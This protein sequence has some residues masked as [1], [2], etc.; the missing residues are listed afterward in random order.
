MKT[1]Y[2]SDLDGTLLNNHAEISEY[3]ENTLN[4]LIQKGLLFSV[5]TARTA[6]STVKILSDIHLNNPV[7][8][9]NG[10][11]IYDI[12]ENK[13]IKIEPLPNDIISTVIG[14]FRA[15]HITGFMYSIENDKLTT[16]Y[17]NLGTI[18]NREFHDVRV[19]RYRKS[20]TKI[21]S[22]YDVKEYNIIYFVLI[23]TKDILQPVYD[24]LKN[25]SNIDVIM[26]RDTYSEVFWYLEIYSVKASKYNALL[27]L[28]KH[29]GY[30]NI[31][32]FGDNLNDL[33]LFKACDERYAVENATIQ[34]K[35]AATAVI[36]SNEN[37][38]VAKWIENNYRF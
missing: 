27:F 10:V 11:I 14:I 33:P 23:D 26:Y 29:Y 38:A 35:S 34:V 17:E 5:A 6:A 15:F 28:R 12:S 19:D 36:G 32:G 18:S 37:D 3:T 1:L 2:I 7:I 9:M 24:S 8:L 21:A 13:Y 20:F 16:Y 22:F 25:F 30:D 4:R 31:I